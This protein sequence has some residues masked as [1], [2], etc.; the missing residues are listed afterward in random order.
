M[1]NNFILFWEECLYARMEESMKKSNYSNV[2]RKRRHFALQILQIVMMIT[3]LGGLGTFAWKYVKGGFAN[4]SHEESNRDVDIDGHNDSQENIGEVGGNVYKTYTYESS[5]LKMKLSKLAS[6]SEDYKKIYDNMT[7]YPEELI[8]ALC[9][10]EELLD[11]AK[12]Y[13]EASGQADGGFTKEELKKDFPLF[14]QWDSRW[15]YVDYG[16]SK[17]GLNGC[18]PTCIS[19]VSVALT[20]N[21][22]ATPDAVAE[23]AEHKGYYQ[24]NSGTAWSMMTEGCRHFGISGEELCLDKNV[25]MNRLSEGHPIICSMGPGDFTSNGHFIV[26]VGTEDGKLIVNDPNSRKRSNQL[27]KYEEISGQ[28]KNLWVFSKS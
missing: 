12:G 16:D 22:E 17:I 9:N 20:G 7:L 25:I 27:W 8:E 4:T 1:T 19:M 18:G 11:Y 15:G 26:L 5:D 14:M 23:Y 3:I 13:L 10:N 21:R 28:I 2:R 6:E 24:E